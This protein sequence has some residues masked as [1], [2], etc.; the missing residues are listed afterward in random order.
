MA[1]NS[2]QEI[3]FMV[4][5]QNASERID[6]ILLLKKRRYFI[7]TKWKNINGSP[8]STNDLRQMYVTMNIGNPVKLMLL[9]PSNAT[10][11]SQKIL[12]LIQ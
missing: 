8:P 2:D 4:K 5:S 11:F 7:D 6:Q 12:F 1:S 3:A 10:Q 9:Y